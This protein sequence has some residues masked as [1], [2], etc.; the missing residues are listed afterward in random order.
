MASLRHRET[1]GGLSG[2]ADPDLPPEPRARRLRGPRSRPAGHPAHGL[3]MRVRLHRRRSWTAWTAYPDGA[4]PRPGS[5]PRSTGSTT[6]PPICA[7]RTSELTR[8]LRRGEA[9]RNRAGGGGRA[10]VLELLARRDDAG[11]RHGHG[12]PGTCTRILAPAF[13]HTL[14]TYGAAAAASLTAPG[15]IT[16]D[17]MTWKMVPAA[18]GYN[19]EIA[20]C[21]STRTTCVSYPVVA[22][23]D[24]LQSDYTFEFV[25]AQ[26]GKWRVTTLAGTGYRNSTASAWHWFTFTQ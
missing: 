22:I 12:R 21:D 14:L 10:S 24:P 23:T 9:G 18:A 8:P 16:V 7:T 13:P 5:S 20:Y 11:H 15:Q 4:A 6:C 1:G 26:P 19:L 3:R 25:G 17:E 2:A